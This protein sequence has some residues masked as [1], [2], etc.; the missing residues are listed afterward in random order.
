MA[1]T[2]SPIRESKEKILFSPSLEVARNIAD[3]DAAAAIEAAHYRFSASM[4]AL[5]N[6]FDLK[7]AELRASLLKEVSQYVESE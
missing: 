1:R 7:A 4:R 3:S 6:A 2:I 5:E